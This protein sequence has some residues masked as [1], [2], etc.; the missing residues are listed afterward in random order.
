[1]DIGF[2]CWTTLFS[3]SASS[4]SGQSFYSEEICNPFCR[5]SE[6]T[7]IGASYIEGL[8]EHIKISYE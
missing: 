8:R 6:N 4:E 5:T 2:F 3:Y 1:M 7:M